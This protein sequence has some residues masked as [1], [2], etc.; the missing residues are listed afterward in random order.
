MSQKFGESIRT[1][2]EARGLS[3]SALA[4]RAGVGRTTIYRIEAGEEP[5]LRTVRRL[6][7]GLGLPMETLL[8]EG[9]A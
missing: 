9:R 3:I 8:R 4:H 6:A 1:L 2:R 7:E 5:S